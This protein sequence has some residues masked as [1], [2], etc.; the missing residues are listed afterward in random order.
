[1]SRKRAKRRVITDGK[2]PQR[3]CPKCGT[4]VI[5]AVIHGQLSYECG[6]QHWGPWDDAIKKVN[7]AMVAK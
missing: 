1:M 5:K 2:L 3:R 7:L 4:Q 6:S